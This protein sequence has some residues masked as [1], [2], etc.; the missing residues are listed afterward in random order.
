[1]T[2]CPHYYIA[3][4]CCFPQAGTEPESHWDQLI[5]VLLVYLKTICVFVS[6]HVH[7]Y[8]YVHVCMCACVLTHSIMEWDL[9]WLESIPTEYLK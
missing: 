4:W 9:E 7:V 1:M 5:C 6:M 2:T 3:N 8:R